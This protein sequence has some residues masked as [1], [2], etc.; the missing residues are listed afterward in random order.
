MQAITVISLKAF[1]ISDSSANLS[2]GELVLIP[3]FDKLDGEYFNSYVAAMGGQIGMSAFVDKWFIGNRSY[4]NDRQEVEILHL[5]A[6]HIASQ[7]LNCLWYVADNAC[8][9]IEI[10]TYVID[11]EEYV[12]RSSFGLGSTTADG[13]VP[14]VDF[15]LSDIN[16]AAS[17][18]EKMIEINDSESRQLTI[19]LNSFQ[20]QAL[21]SPYHFAD[22]A[23]TNRLERALSILTMARTNSF[24]PLKISL[25]MSVLECLFTTDSN[26]TVH[27][28]SER[29]AFYIGTNGQDRLMIY[30]LI[31]Q[32]YSIR[33]KFFHGQALSKKNADHLSLK[34]TSTKVD[35]LLRVILTKA[36]IIDADF[37]SKKPD[38]FDEAL[39][40]MIFGQ[41]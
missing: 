26:E 30:S 9:V 6:K 13:E 25:Y 14:T 8:S 27:K 7:F 1:N 10:Y 19:E 41:A 40:T 33:S 23:K 32:A 2:L 38:K 17:I 20:P 18:Y 22:Q 3:P 24:I 15:S 28:V 16:T 36:L 11:G 39:N 29:A 21:H 35:Q 37:F 31:K 34:T 12:L 5:K 4:I